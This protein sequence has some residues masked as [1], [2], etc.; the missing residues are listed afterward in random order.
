MTRIEEIIEYIDAH[1]EDPAYVVVR[2]LHAAGYSYPE[3]SEAIKQWV[4]NFPE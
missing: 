3:I 2:D 1:E 4:S